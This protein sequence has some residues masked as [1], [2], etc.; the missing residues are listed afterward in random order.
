MSEPHSRAL[1]RPPRLEVVHLYEEE[2]H[3]KCLKNKME[4]YFNEKKKVKFSVLIRISFVSKMFSTSVCLKHFK[5]FGAESGL[6]NTQV[7]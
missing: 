2:M 4:M 5:D 3:G 1:R 7:R 6:W